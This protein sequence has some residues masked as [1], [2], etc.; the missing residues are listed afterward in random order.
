MSVA[1]SLNLSKMALTA[2]HAWLSGLVAKRCM[3]SLGVNTFTELPE[4]HRLLQDATRKFA[5]EALVPIAGKIDKSC[6]YPEATV[7]GMG[8]LG[9]MGIDVPEEYGG[10]GFDTLA[11]AV[12]CE[13][14][15][16]GCASHGVIMSAH[17]SLYCSP[18][19]YYG[20]DQQKRDHLSPFLTGDMVGCFGLTEPGNGSDAGAASTTARDAGDKWV[21]NG[22]KAWITN[23]HQAKGIVAFA[24]TDKNMKHKG[25]SAF[26]VPMDIEG[27]SLGKKEDKLGIKASSTSNVIFEDCAIPKENLLGTPGLGFKIA[28]VT[29]DGGRIGI[30]AQALG[31]AQNAFE[32]AVNYALTRNSMGKALS[33]HQM[34]QSKIADMALRIEQ[35]RL[36]MY[37]AAALKDA[38]KPFSKEAAMAKLSASETA[39]YVAHQS[40]QVLGGMGY[41]TSTSSERNYRD[42]RITEIYEGTS[43]IQRLVISGAVCK[44]FGQ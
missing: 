34:I 28:M 18:I 38:G 33:K 14:I 44:E 43:E 2:R 15:S 16:R 3:S 21:L 24:T 19:K 4:D 6:E 1:S 41:V 7:K 12:S 5:E 39:T 25:I 23:A 26:I 13:E 17:N 32:T 29:L 27:V 11:Y 37:K 36:M 42:A 35:S 30:A 8:D 22:T 40:I 9:L 20:T 31:I 10:A